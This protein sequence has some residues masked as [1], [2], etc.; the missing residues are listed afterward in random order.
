MVGPVA[1][2]GQYTLVASPKHIADDLGGNDSDYKAC[3][4]YKRKYVNFGEADKLISK[5]IYYAEMYFFPG[6]HQSIN[7]LIVTK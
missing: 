5:L 1:L 4:I 3:F 6:F 2:Q 7:R